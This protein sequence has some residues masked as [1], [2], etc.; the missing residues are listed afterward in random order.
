MKKLRL[1]VDDVLE[2]LRKKDVFNIKMV[3]YAILETDG[4]LTVMLKPE[5]R[6]AVNDDLNLEVE[7]AGFLRVVISDGQYIQ[8]DIKGCNLS[9]KDVER[10]I[11]NK[12]IN[13][14]KVMLMTINKNGK[15]DIIKKEDAR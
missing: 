2:A 3:E 15:I 8:S 7:D 6:P 14:K 13:I 9:V 10:I 11:K 1:T 5:Y 4:I 12:K